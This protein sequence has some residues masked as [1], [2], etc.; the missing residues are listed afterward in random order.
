MI[1]TYHGAACF[2]IQFG[3]TVLAFNPISK[4][5]SNYKPARFGADIALISLR[6]P[7]FN[8][9]DQV[10][11]KS[12]DTFVIRGPGEYEVKGIMVR[13]FETKA[14]YA[15]SSRINTIY[16]VEFEGMTICFLGVL[17]KR[18]LSTD[19]LESIEDIDLLF[20][21]IGGSSNSK[22]VSSDVLDATNAYKLAVSLEPKIIIPTLYSD[23]KS[24]QDGLVRFM[25][26]GGVDKIERK[27]KL[28]V[29]QKDVAGKGGEIVA[30]NVQ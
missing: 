10:K 22:Q 26:E 16:I 14:E 3:D 12:K 11:N 29:K 2:K 1:I 27:D 17:S 18:E 8:G 30:L 6:H 23:D 24:N 9:V 15:G 20:V 13:G 4:D 21:P 28:T 7:D 19:I 25:E 5:S